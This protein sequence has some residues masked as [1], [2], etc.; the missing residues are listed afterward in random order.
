[1]SIRLSNGPSL[2]AGVA[3]S[4]TFTTVHFFPSCLNVVGGVCAVD[5]GE[6]PGPPPPIE[7]VG[8]L[9]TD[10]PV[11]PTEDTSDPFDIKFNFSPSVTL[12]NSSS[13]LLTFTVHVAERGS[14][15]STPANIH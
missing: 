4:Q 8:S 3:D 9:A 14:T 11:V 1:M 6:V 5:Q 7:Y 13:C 2:D 12:A 10:C 15:A